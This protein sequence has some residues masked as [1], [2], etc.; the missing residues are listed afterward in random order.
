VI[1]IDHTTMGQTCGILPVGI[2]SAYVKTEGLKWNL[3]MSRLLTD[4]FPTDRS[5]WETSFDGDV[6]SSNHLLPSEP[7]VQITTNRP[8]MWC[9]EIKANLPKLV[10]AST[11][12]SV[13][14][15]SSSGGPSRPKVAEVSQGLRDLSIGL[16]KAA[17][18]VGRE[19]EKLQSASASGSGSGFKPSQQAGAEA[20]DSHDEGA[21]EEASPPVRNTDK[22]R[23]EAGWSRLD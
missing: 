11:N 21:K 10:T 12:T 2:D 17:Q 6:S 15:Q 9:I 7:L 16:A 4:C 18:G 13:K 8:V 20:H 23:E 19:L 5:D 14:R 22:L 3:G 1:E